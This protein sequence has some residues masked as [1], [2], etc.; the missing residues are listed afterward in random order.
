[1]L[2]SN[3]LVLYC[4]GGS[5]KIHTSGI[6]KFYILNF[7]EKVRESVVDLNHEVLFYLCP[8]VKHTINLQC[9]KLILPAGCKISSV[10]TSLWSVT[11]DLSVEV[12]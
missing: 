11:G 7:N 5:I 6:T 1:M 4:S 2:L 8:D 3:R 10:H 9:S 12:T